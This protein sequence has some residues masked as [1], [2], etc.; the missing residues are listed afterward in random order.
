MFSR[1]R[2]VRRTLTEWAER[3]ATSTRWCALSER[4]MLRGTFRVSLHSNRASGADYS[5]NRDPSLFTRFTNCAAAHASLPR[6][7]ATCSCIFALSGWMDLPGVG[8][9][10]LGLGLRLRGVGQSL[11]TTAPTAHAR[12]PSSIH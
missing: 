1:S 8:W 7:Q 5:V 9:H 2:P 10:L 4:T 11:V 12:N 3:A 6:L